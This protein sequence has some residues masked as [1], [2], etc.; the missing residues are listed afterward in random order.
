M[1]LI[2]CGYYIIIYPMALLPY[3]TKSENEHINNLVFL[4]IIIGNLPPKMEHILSLL[5]AMYITLP[6]IE[7]VE[8]SILDYSTHF[9]T[10]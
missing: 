7:C 2:K 3:L 9:C 4:Q 10:L 6:I 5:L 1:H 8:K